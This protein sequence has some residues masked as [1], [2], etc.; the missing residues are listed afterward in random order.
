MRCGS[1]EQRMSAPD[2]QT[3]QSAPNLR[4]DGAASPLRIVFVTSEP[5]YREGIE[6]AFRASP[7][8]VL[9]G[10][11]TINDAIALA[12]SRG[13]DMAVIDASN[14]GDLVEMAKALALS[15]P[16]LP[17]VA[18][19]EAATAE[20]VGTALEAGI[21]GYIRKGVAG[22]EFVRILISIGEGV[23][24]LPLEFGAVT[25]RQ[26][27]CLNGATHEQ[28]R[29]YGLT[30]REQQ[31]LGCVARAL[32]N[33]EVA[34][35]LQISEKTVKHYMTVIMEKLQVR[36]RVQAVQKANALK[37]ANAVKWDVAS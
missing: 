36:N 4:P 10:G 2:S 37:K 7:S 22:D 17:I 30:A 13:A 15:C 18:V 20:D 27:L 11:T 1:S 3:T 28:N 6:V 32:T 12:R 16:Q 19:S 14:S 31:I 9:L 29:P 8:L 21:R 5:L 25:L 34:R 33:K 35:E 26:S 23:L 24:Y